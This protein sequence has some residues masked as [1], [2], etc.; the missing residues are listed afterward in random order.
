MD[1]EAHLGRHGIEVARDPS[2]EDAR[3]LRVRVRREV[4]PLLESI[5][6]GIVEHLCALAGMLGD[7]G[8]GD[9]LGEMGLGRAQ[10]LLARRAKKCE[11]E[12]KLR[13]SGGR[14]VVLDFSGEE[15]VLME[16]ARKRGT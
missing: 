16:T 7:A 14:D 1:V 3:F 10:R 6:P 9:G 4:M 8:D 12:L 2:N 15:A 11:R 5:S 13:V